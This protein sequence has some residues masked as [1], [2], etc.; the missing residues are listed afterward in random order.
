VSHEGASDRVVSEAKRAK[1]VM[2]SPFPL[3]TWPLQRRQEPIPALE[4]NEAPAVSISAGASLS[5]LDRV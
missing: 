1:R 5:A 4:H 3:Y 2:R